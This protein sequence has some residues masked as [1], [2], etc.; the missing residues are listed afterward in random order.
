MTFF[1]AAHGSPDFLFGSPPPEHIFVA[2]NYLCVSY[3]LNV[4]A[5]NGE[6]GELGSGWCTGS[7]APPGSQGDLCLWVFDELIVAVVY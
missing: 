6:H 4:R 1:Q 2:R 7:C 3:L 5:A